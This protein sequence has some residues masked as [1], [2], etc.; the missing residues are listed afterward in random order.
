[1]GRAKQDK[2]NTKQLKAIE[3]LA[4][5]ETKSGTAKKIGVNQKTIYAWYKQDKFKDELDKKVI[6]VKR[7]VGVKLA[8]NVEPLMDKLID[9]AL[10]SKDERVSL[11]AITYALDRLYGK[12]TTKIETKD[13]TKQI[14]NVE[15]IKEMLND[16][17]IQVQDVDY[18]EDNNVDNNVEDNNNNVED[19]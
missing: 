5:G 11:Q 3:L 15:D 13:T 14:T 9:I 10:K 1:M 6:E 16:I 8:L 12:T 18:I 4:S 17:D 7:E 2:L 19:N